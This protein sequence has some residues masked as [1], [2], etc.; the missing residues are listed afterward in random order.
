MIEAIFNSLVN[1]EL[2]RDIVEANLCKIFEHV[3]NDLIHAYLKD[4][5]KIP[6]ISEVSILLL[7]WSET[8]FNSLVNKELLRDIFEANLCKIF[9][10]VFNDLIDNCLKDKL[11]IL[12]IPEHTKPGAGEVEERY[13]YELAGEQDSNA[14]V[15]GGEEFDSEEEALDSDEGELGGGEAADDHLGSPTSEV[16]STIQ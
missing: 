6:D 10:R 7:F 16:V 9:E 4:K 8:I 12:D 13:L 1:K 5:L 2:L 15:L 11:K 14:R 3:Y